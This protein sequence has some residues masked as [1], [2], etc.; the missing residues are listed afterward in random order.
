MSGPLGGNRRKPPLFNDP[1][2]DWLARAYGPKLRMDNPDRRHELPFQNPMRGKGEIDWDAN[3]R[4]LENQ[5]TDAFELGSQMKVTRVE[6]NK[7]APVRIP[8][9]KRGT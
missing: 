8:M 2:Q 9:K 3:E 4:A 1:A 5:R 7:P 6:R